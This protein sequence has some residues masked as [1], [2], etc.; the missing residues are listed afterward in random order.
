MRHFFRTIVLFSIISFAILPQENK[1]IHQ[2]ESEYFSSHP[3]KVMSENSDLIY[4]NPQYKIFG[5]Q[6]ISHSVYGFHP[7]WVSDA[8][9][10]DYYFS[11]LT[12][13][14]YFSAEVDTGVATTGGILSTHSWS[15]TQVV[16]YC[17][18]HNIKIHLAVTMFA[19]HD[20]VLANA[21][22]RTNLANNI[23][24]KIQLRNADGANIDFE[25][26]A[27][28]QSANYRL[29]IN[30][31]GTLLKANNL[32]LAICIPAI[33]WSGIYS[34]TF[35]TANN[36][37][38]DYYFL[39]AY[40]YY[41]R[42]SS[43]AGP[44][45]PIT[46]GTAIYH[47]TRS[48]TSYLTAGAT[49]GRLL[50][51]FG[52]YGYDW[53]VTSSSRMASVKASTDGIAKTYTQINAAL[54]GISASD[55]FF[56]ATYSVPWYRYNDGTDWHQVW[57][58][59]EQSI[60]IK[61]D[62]VKSLNLAGTG[63]WALSYDGAYTGMWNALKT[64]FASTPNSEYT[65]LDNFESSVGHFDKSLTYSGSTVGIDAAS[66]SAQSVEEANNGWGSLK[67]VLKDNASV[68]TAWT[69]RCLSGSG[70]ISS[71]ISLSS[72]GHIGLWLKTSSA[73]SGAQI[74]VTIDDGASST[75]ISPKL[76]IANN[77]TW[78]LYEWDL[79]SAGWSSFSGGNGTISG[80]AVTIDAIMFYAPN[81]SADWTIY[82]DDVSFNP[83]GA[84][85]VELTNF[86]C[87]I[88]GSDILLSWNTA[89]ELNLALFEVERNKD[90]SSFMKIGSV[91]AN[92][93]SNSLKEYS[94]K[95]NN[96]VAGNYQYRLKMV[97]TDGTSK[98]GPIIEAEINRPK[99][100]ALYQNYPNPFNLSTTINYAIPMDSK[101]VLVVYRINGEKVAEMVN[102]MQTAGSYNIPFSA[103]GL[104]SGT[105]L[106]RL[107]VYPT[108]GGA[109]EF[110]QTKKMI[111]LK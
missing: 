90:N 17:K 98:Y 64:S 104:A 20:R 79:Q 68:S 22:Y 60:N 92:G 69:V 24:A 34:S 72:T 5:L 27:S 43:T 78:T 23:L 25:A 51:G 77:D 101:V 100:Y 2:L 88:N 61:Y 95:D 15:T 28:A 62:N 81:A 31:L 96:L 12:H 44:V 19:K 91:N 11:L 63:M 74:A 67:L 35:F 83:N 93:N 80:S 97:D 18:A 57:Y 13:V 89:T 33:D 36:S 46:T 106:Y 94:Y 75:E 107:Q 76:T 71:N 42:G 56:D 50:A 84:L 110:V 54:P 82:F 105:Y 70:T 10:S 65:S 21:T 40:D 111:L 55:I 108:A 6:T 45:S 7:Y 26:V 14:A 86:N 102:E 73:P 29:F 59:D 58:E 99:E 32:E 49:A 4:K 8:T 37:V 1:S 16:N 66:S 9:A 85:P 48:I 109:G 38:V 87:S 41:Y 3:E 30:E 39:M 47:V 52:Y 103:T 53:T